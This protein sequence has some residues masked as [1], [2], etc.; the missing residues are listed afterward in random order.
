MPSS[1]QPDP[2]R[3]LPQ[4]KALPQAKKPQVARPVAGPQQAKPAVAR[5]A[6]AQPTAAAPGSFA[7]GGANAPH[8]A[9][10]SRR[11]K[12][13]SLPMLAI[14]GS[15]ALAITG[16]GY[17]FVYVKPQGSAPTGGSAL[18]DGIQSTDSTPTGYLTKHVV[19]EN[20]ELAFTVPG[21][22]SDAWFEISGEPEGA[23]LNED[24]GAFTW[25]PTEAQGPGQYEVTV[26]VTRDKQRTE[27]NLT[28]TVN[29]ANEP[30][31]LAAI[32]G[33]VLN[34]NV[35]AEL[36]LT[37]SATDSDLP[38]QKLKYELVSPPPGA[39]IDPS[40][41]ELRW[42]PTTA[43]PGQIVALTVR[44]TDDA[45]LALSAAQTF[46]VTLENFADPLQQLIADLQQ[47][48][49]VA[50]KL[51]AEGKPLL[52]GQSLVLEIPGGRL[53]TYLY[54]DAA[55]ADADAA[56][57]SRDAMK[58]DDRPHTWMGPT[59]FFKKD[60]LVAYYT[61]RDEAAVAALV[62]KLG[63]PVA[64]TVT[65]AFM[66]GAEL[67]SSGAGLDGTMPGG[68]AK[69]QASEPTSPLE[70]A[71]LDL[72][73]RKRLFAPQEYPAIRKLYAEQFLAEQGRFVEMA[74][75]ADHYDLM[76]WLDKRPDVKE[77]LFTAIDPQYDKVVEALTLFHD[78]WKQYPKEIEK[79]WQLAIATAVVWDNPRGVYNYRQ[80]QERAK[81]PLPEQPMLTAV[82]NFKYF[83]DGESIMQ[84]RA[85]F[86]PWEF[87]VHLINHETPYDERVWAVQNYVAA[88]AMFGKCYHDVPYDDLMLNTGSA[89][90]KMNGH[91]YTLANLRDIGGV[92]AHQADFAARVGKSMGVPAEY[93]WGEGNSLGLHA[94]V[95]WVELKQVTPTAI[96]FALESHGRYNIDNYY[97]GKLHD[98]HTGQVVTDRDLELRLQ[99]VG[100]NPRAKRHAALLMTAFPRLSEMTG[101]DTQ[102][103]IIF[104]RDTIALCPGNEEAWSEL[105]RLCKEGK[106]EKKHQ[107]VI[108]V[109]LDTMFRTFQRVPDFT[110][111][112]FDDFISFQGDMAMRL[113][114][115][116]QLAQ[117]YEAATRPDLACEAR[118]T[119]ADYQVKENKAMEAVEGLAMTIKKFPDEG[120]YVPRMLDKLEEVCANFEGADA[121]LL[122]FYSE[123]LPT[124]PKTR[125]GSPS[126]YCILMYERGIK[127]FR[128]HGQEQVAAALEQELAKI[129]G[130]QA[131]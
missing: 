18:A 59:H 38:A 55:A 58:I 95:M 74:F 15:L 3:G 128:E 129:R 72:H 120:R 44:V 41:G 60:R 9:V 65:D 119:L 110:W 93:V 30:P 111:K 20:A 109:A 73:Q 113:K 47:A 84:G 97:V 46:N 92:C 101:M 16:A 127:K 96:V 2:R 57:V 83:I 104:L 31:Q 54:A 40:T 118:L 105:A 1:Q 11:K 64:S 6:A 7:F 63:T 87:L 91:I 90:A 45:P 98:P 86:L 27:H 17:Y 115:Y 25:T 19:E 68:D 5:P 82:E 36:A 122:R 126:G 26:V 51:G 81:S 116:E 50:K 62:G 49:V 106:I 76:Q 39:K 66:P 94:W 69:P 13:S 28:I 48:G 85:Q 14:I 80:H 37:A 29:E 78:I 24:T 12:K 23:T 103:Q 32:E 89:Q 10:A 117:L 130:G 70:T 108:M 121:A 77:E 67:A 21:A 22:G 35:A 42:Q 124:V 8:K 71:L 43:E 52:G 131:L 4:G 114:A 56:R 53:Y 79:Y 107:Q 125:G 61:G 88:R 33:V 75:G 123:F 100:A 99:T 102:Q 34:R 112:I